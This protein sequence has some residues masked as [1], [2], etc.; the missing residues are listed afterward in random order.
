MSFRD[1]DLIVEVAHPKIIADYGELILE[2]TDLFVGSPTCFADQ[3]LFEKLKNSAS[4]F[5][6]KLL[7]PSGALWGANDIQKMAEVGSLKVG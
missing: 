5:G 6:R 2:H 4:R 1:I 3:E 7:V